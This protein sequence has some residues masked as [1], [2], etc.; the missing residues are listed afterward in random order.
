MTTGRKGRLPPG[1]RRGEGGGE[2]PA[3]VRLMIS[4]ILPEQEREF[5]L[6]DLEEDPIRSWLREILSAFALRLALGTPRFG[7]NN[8]QRQPKGDGMFQELLQDLRFGLRSMIRS[9]G[10]TVVALL[11]MALGIGANT[12]MFSIVNGVILRPIRYPEASRI[13]R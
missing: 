10:F 3:P 11:T 8:P 12:A 4:L 9:P 1:G 7:P 13:V 2:V 6:G 5:F